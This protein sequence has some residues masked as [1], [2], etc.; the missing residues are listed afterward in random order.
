MFRQA[1]HD[2]R[3]ILRLSKGWQAPQIKLN[4]NLTQLQNKMLKIFIADDHFQVRQGLKQ[5]ITEE[6]QSVTFGEAETGQQAVEMASK[7]KWDIL[8]MDMNMPQKN[9]INVLKELRKNSINTPALII[10]SHDSIQYAQHAKKA[11]ASAFLNK[12][13]TSENL[14]K[15]IKEILSLKL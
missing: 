12:E 4:K 1:Q 5:I 15:S 8:I 9:G 6:Y 3:V 7:E 14:V 11:G 10:S 2:I 13:N